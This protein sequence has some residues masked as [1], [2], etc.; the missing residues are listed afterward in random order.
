MQ[1]TE[2]IKISVKFHYLLYFKEIYS[3]LN[4]QVLSTEEAN[5]E[6]SKTV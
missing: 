6:K 1:K 4:I 3:F 2:K 5:K